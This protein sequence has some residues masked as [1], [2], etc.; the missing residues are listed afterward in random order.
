MYQ[1]LY[2][3]WRDE[4]LERELRPLPDGFYIELSGYIKEL[5]RRLGRL[6]E[7]TID[8]RLLEREME[9]IVK[10]VEDLMRI[11]RE[12]IILSTFRGGQPPDKLTREESELAG[13]VLPILKAY[14]EMVKGLTGGRAEGEET[15]EVKAKRILVRFIREI[16][17]IVGSDLKMYGPFRQEDIASLP[18]ENAKALIEQGVAVKIKV[19]DR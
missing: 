4:V 8:A 3:A 10:M 19:E 13:D 2:K 16:P 9:N 17:A 14:G 1:K 18:A 5:K 6:N 11:R 7:G 12:K 15:R